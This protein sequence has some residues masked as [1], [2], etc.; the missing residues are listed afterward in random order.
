MTRAALIAA[1]LLVAG[2]GD[3]TYTSERVEGITVKT[4]QVLSAWVEAVHNHVPG[5]A[6]EAVATI[7]HLTYENRVDMNAGIELFFAVLGQ[8]KYDTGGNRAAEVVVSIAK[9]AGMP[10]AVRFLERAAILHADAVVF[11]VRLPA[12]ADTTAPLPKRGPTSAVSS[13]SAMPSTPRAPVQPPPLLT[14]TRLALDADGELLGTGVVDWNWVFARSL[15]DQIVHG[16]AQGRGGSCVDAQCIGGARASITSVEEP[17]IAAWYHATTAY[18]FAQGLYGDATDHLHR[19]GQVLPD[20]PQVLYDRACYA[21]ILGLPAQQLLLLDAKP[22]TFVARI[23][24]LEAT[25]GEAERLFRRAVDAEP[26]FVEARVRLGRLLNVRG[27]H[28]DAAAELKTAL[29]AQP[30]PIVAYFANLFAARAAQALGHVQEA[31]DRYHDASALFPDAQSAI[32]GISQAALLGAK[33]PEA[34]APIQRLGPRSATF[35]SDP[36]W[37][38]PMASGRDANELMQHLWAMSR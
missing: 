3:P 24:R 37:T 35:E 2:S 22:G 30:Q 25:N 6:D 18:M 20:D 15:L 12:P 21:E 27:A 9:G 4:T 19:G 1:L 10:D 31:A 34:V 11:G 38:Y 14:N 26:S 33:V 16:F 13:N 8:R 7:R 17:F 5:H 29:G 32:L 36:W 28:A 23:P